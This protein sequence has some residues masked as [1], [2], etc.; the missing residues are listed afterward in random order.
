M[1]NVLQQIR[2]GMRVYDSQGEEIGTVDWVRMSDEDPTTPEAETVTG[3]TNVSRNGTLTDLIWNA[4][5]TDEVPEPLQSRL[6]R[7]GFVR[8][9]AKSLFAADRYV[10]PDQISSV[11]NDH[12]TLKV[13]REAL[14]RRE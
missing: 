6:L 13:P 10:M 2:K 7:E 5:R 9:D 3:D 1:E 8:I 14:I 4:F 12:V 11:A